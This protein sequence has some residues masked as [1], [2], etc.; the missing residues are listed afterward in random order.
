MQENNQIPFEDA[1]VIMYRTKEFNKKP[2]VNTYCLPA[3]L[4]ACLPGTKEFNKKSIND[5]N[6]IN[7]YSKR[8][9]KSYDIK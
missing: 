8:M 2:M 9:S 1:F 7:Y 6:W 4:I 3:C 5:P